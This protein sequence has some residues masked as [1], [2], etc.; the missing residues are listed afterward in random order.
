MGVG[1]HSTLRKV[2]VELQAPAPAVAVIA[3]CDAAGVRPLPQ[4][5][6]VLVRLAEIGTVG[7]A[8]HPQRAK[9]LF[10][11]HGASGNPARRVVAVRALRPGNAGAFSLANG[12]ADA[13][14]HTLAVGAPLI[15]FRLA[16][17]FAFGKAETSDAVFGVGACRFTPRYADI[18]D[19]ISTGATGDAASAL[20]RAAWPAP[21]STGL[22][23]AL[24][25]LAALAGATLFL[26]LLGRR[27]VVTDTQ[28]GGEARDETKRG[29]TCAQGLDDPVETMRI[30]D[31]PILTS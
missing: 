1:P 3:R 16:R 31:A 8:Q 22:R 21:G 24:A 11:D 12:A 10:I 7:V 6:A 2:E 14:V 25:L 23:L 15:A 13:K 19:A 9:R 30:H 18:V 27:L 26:A 20:A 29:A 4:I 5:A 17:R 28:Q